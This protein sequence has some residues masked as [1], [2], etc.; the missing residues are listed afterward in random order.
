MI[1]S[2]GAT[3]LIFLQKPAYLIYFY[4]G[5]NS[6]SSGAGNPASGKTARK[7]AAADIFQR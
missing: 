6:K 2:S 7:Q 5:M 1:W 4:H 3:L